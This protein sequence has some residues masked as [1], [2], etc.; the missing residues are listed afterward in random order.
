MRLSEPKA[1]K[2]RKKS[3][4]QRDRESERKIVA[5]GDDK[6]GRVARAHSVS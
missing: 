6:K 1:R 3:K 4:K 2:R 5:H